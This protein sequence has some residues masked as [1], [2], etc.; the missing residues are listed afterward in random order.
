[1]AD[2]VVNIDSTDR[3][4]YV[5]ARSI[6][7]TD[8]LN[9]KINTCSFK[10]FDPDNA[11]K[12]DA[13][14]S[15]EVYDPDS[16][17]IFGGII[18][19]VEERRVGIVPGTENEL[20]EYTVKAQDYT[21]LL[22]KKLVVETYENKTC[23][24]IIQ[25]MIGKYFPNEGFTF[26]NTQ[27][28]PTITQI[29]F[30]YKK[31]DDAI[32]SLADAAGYEWYIDYDKDI[33]F[34]DVTSE[35]S[36]FEFTDSTTNWTDLIIKPDKTQLRNRVYV[37][38]GIYY[39]DPFTQEIEADGT[40]KVFLLAYTPNVDNFSVEISSVS[41]TVGLKDID[42][43]EDFDFLLNRKEKSLSMGGSAWALANTPLTS[44]TVLDVTYDYEIPVLIVQEDTT[45]ISTLASLEGGDG[46]YEYLIVD[47]NITSIE[48]ARD[49]AVAELTT[50]ANVI[51]RGS[52]IS[53]DVAG[54]T[55]GD[56]IT[57]DSTRRGIDADYLV[58]KVTIKQIST[59]QLKYQIEFTGTLYNFVD[60]LLNLYKRGTEIVLGIDEVLDA[61]NGFI[62]STDGLTHTD[63]V[64]TYSAPPFYWSNDEGTTTN[65]IRWSLF[66]WSDGLQKQDQIKVYENTSVS[67]V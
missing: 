61:F 42:D 57:I 44:G 48:A 64:F 63:P 51:T 55:S 2:I 21:K 17:K 52:L 33:H 8:E 32:S 14:E 54:I 3:T 19:S 34:F 23:K 13:S 12:P 25:E 9:A 37:R 49:R 1:M 39:S 5:K 60:F 43:A 15:I 6:S 47:K 20:L 31:G 10:T 40:A 56:I 18:A 4:E 35:S 22:Q 58:T 36:S 38:G 28:G 11:W 16:N 46:A 45:S 62:D 59:N 53:Y 41:K 65:K 26:T 24:E 27:D 66:E 29:S 30:N 67:I 7:I 50:Y